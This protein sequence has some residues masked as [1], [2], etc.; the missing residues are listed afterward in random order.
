MD[1]RTELRELRKAERRL[2]G[3]EDACDRLGSR[4]NDESTA[5]ALLRTSAALHKSVS[6]SMSSTEKGH[7]VSGKRPVSNPFQID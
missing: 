3:M 4:G 5:R 1:D 6:L 2:S 7:T